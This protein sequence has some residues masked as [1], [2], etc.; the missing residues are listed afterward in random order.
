MKA[1]RAFHRWIG[2]A[3]ALFMI[4]TASTGLFLQLNLLVTGTAPP[5]H[6][7]R[8]YVEATPIEDGEKVAAAA[9]EAIAIARSKGVNL[10]VTQLTVDL[11]GGE[12]NVILGDPRNR[13][14]V[15]V[16]NLRTGKILP[17]P[18]EKYM[19]HG[20]V[21]DI[22]AWYFIGIFGQFLSA[23]LSIGLIILSVTG[24]QMY[25]KLY[26]ARRKLGRLALFWQ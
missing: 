21:Q 16:V 5:G 19:L 7:E 6:E 8:I 14:P 11:K 22:H 26:A 9:R 1:L 10:D 12:T 20:I 25:W 15:A 3:T 18:F 13:E 17:S 23:L 2:A 24:L 4:V